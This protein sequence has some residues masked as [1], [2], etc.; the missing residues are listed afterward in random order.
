MMA[1]MHTVLAG[2]KAL[3]CHLSYEGIKT[4]RECCGAAGFSKLSN[5]AIDGASALVT[6]E[7][8]YVVMS[9]QT[10]RALLKSGKQVVVKGKKLTKNLSYINDLP[11]LMKDPKTIRV[12]APA[13][14]KD[15]FMNLNNCADLLK[16]NAL[17]SIGRGL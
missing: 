10:A 5:F 2:L 16:W 1:P 9:L 12:V 13:S 14:D 7:G 17:Y 15:F 4:M 6:L 11:I 3:F 8:D